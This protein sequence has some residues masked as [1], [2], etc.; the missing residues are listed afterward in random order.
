MSVVDFTD[1]EGL[2]ALG[3]EVLWERE[4]VGV[5][6]SHGGFEIP[7]TGRLRSQAG[8]ETGAGG[9]A[10]CDLAVGALEEGAARGEG[11]DVGRMDVF[12]T[13]AVELRAEVIDC[14]EEDVEL[15]GSLGGGREG[16][17]EKKDKR[18]DR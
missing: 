4:G 6:L 18:L 13:V 2:V 12:V 1:G 15:F 7:T 16:E 8:H 11:I 9:A 14:D 3:F 17:A 10:D 5:L